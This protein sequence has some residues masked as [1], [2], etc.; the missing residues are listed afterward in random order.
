MK[1]SKENVFAMG[2]DVAMLLA[3]AS[4]FF[5][6]EASTLHGIAAVVLASVGAVAMAQ[7]GIDKDGWSTNLCIMVAVLTILGGVV[8]IGFLVFGHYLCG[9]AVATWSLVG[10]LLIFGVGTIAA[11]T[12]R[13]NWNEIETATLAALAGGMALVL[14]ILGYS[15]SLAM[16]VAVVFAE[17]GATD[18]Y[19]SPEIKSLP[20]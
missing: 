16:I 5:L 18:L 7:Y 9:S 15:G 3:V 2:L 11:N 6:P 10:L 12:Y 4:V 8:A 19:K 14:V 1:V 13:E 20:K 17:S